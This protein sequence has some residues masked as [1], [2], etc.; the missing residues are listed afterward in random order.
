MACGVSL[1]RSIKDALDVEIAL[2]RGGWT[3]AHSHVGQTHM[4][5]VGVGVGVDG[6]GANAEFAAG[7]NDAAGDFAA[8]GDEDGLEQG[9]HGFCG[10]QAAGRF[11]RKAVRPSRASGSERMLA[12]RWAVS[13][14][15]SA[16]TG[17]FATA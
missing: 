17:W 9:A 16:V 12:M 13:S 8:V 2:A 4:A 10:T 15:S 11:S 6:N 3:D 7:G 1:S 14:I 5:A